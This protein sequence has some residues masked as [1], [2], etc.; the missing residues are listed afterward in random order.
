M[1]LKDMP[2]DYDQIE[3]LRLETV[4]KGMRGKA[5]R[6]R[7]KPDVSEAAPKGDFNPPEEKELSEEPK[8]D[9][10]SEMQPAMRGY[11]RAMEKKVNHWK[12]R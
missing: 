3:D 9:I 2:P 10:G 12:V 4:L 11:G 7:P 8:G 6:P 5:P 1:N